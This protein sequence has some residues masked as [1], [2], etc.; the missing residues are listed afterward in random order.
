MKDPDATPQSTALLVIIP[1]FSGTNWHDVKAKLISL[2]TTCVGTSGIP[3]TYL[4]RETRQPW[5]DTEQMTNLQERRIAKKVHKA[6][7]FELDNIELF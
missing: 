6:N 2:L 7:T 3:L 5:E 1:T 4:I